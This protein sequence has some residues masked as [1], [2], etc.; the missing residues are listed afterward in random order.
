[1]LLPAILFLTCFKIP[2]RSLLVWLRFRG[3][4][5]ACCGQCCV[6][7]GGIMMLTRAGA[8][9]LEPEPHAATR[10]VSV[11]VIVVLYIQNVLIIQCFIY[12]MSSLCSAFYTECPYYGT[13]V[14]LLVLF[15]ALHAKCPYDVV[16]YMQSVRITQCF[17]CKVFLLF[18]ALY[19]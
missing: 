2:R 17:L 5:E 12:R 9:H 8:A 11:L 6:L 10:H 14:S 7:M 1:M 18:S 13:K 3:G 15:S 4:G 19:A 16:L